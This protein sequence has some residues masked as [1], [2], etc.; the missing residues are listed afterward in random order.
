[1][2]QNFCVYSIDLPNSFRL[3]HAL[4]FSIHAGKGVIASVDNMRGRKKVSDVE[5]KLED[6]NSEHTVYQDLY[7]GDY[8][9]IQYAMLKRFLYKHKLD[10][11][12]L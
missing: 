9:T 12:Y 6:D 1:M 8:F 5:K 11:K 7:I 2:V 3:N 4:D 10:I